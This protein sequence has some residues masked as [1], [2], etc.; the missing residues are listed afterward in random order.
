[1]GLQANAASVDHLDS[2]S[3][4]EIGLLAASTTVGVV[5]PTEN[6]NAGKTTFAPA[7][8]LIDA[9][10]A[11]AISTDFNPGSAP[12]PSQ[13]MAMAIAARYQKLLPAECINAATINAAHAIGVGGKVGSIETGKRADLLLLD[14]TDYRQIVYEFGGNLVDSVFCGGRPAV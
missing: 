3:D 4:E 5:I 10:C 9:G 14:V 13:P 12:C 7:R 11:V 1:M 2:I 8:K 6:F